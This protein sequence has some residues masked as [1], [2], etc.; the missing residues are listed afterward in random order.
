MVLVEFL[1]C[2]P[3]CSWFD[4]FHHSSLVVFDGKGLNAFFKWI[5]V[6]FNTIY[7]MFPKY[8][9]QI[10]FQYTR[11]ISH[12]MKYNIIALTK[13]HKMIKIHFLFHNHH[14]VK[15]QLRSH[16][17]LLLDKIC[18]YSLKCYFL[19]LVFCHILPDLLLGK[20]F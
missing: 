15:V 18:K 9:L 12:I 4:G 5:E 13:Y 1:W 8:N 17:P 7:R 10:L 16:F 14:I 19:F 3:K 6:H 11:S 20:F 2:L